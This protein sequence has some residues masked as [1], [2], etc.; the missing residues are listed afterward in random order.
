MNYRL[1]GL[2]YKVVF[3]PRSF[4]YHRL[5]GPRRMDALK[6]V[7]ILKNRMRFLAKH[8]PEKLPEHLFGF[9]EILL[10]PDRLFDEILDFVKRDLPKYF[11][12]KP[13]WTLQLTSG[14]EALRNFRARSFRTV[15]FVKMLSRIRGWGAGKFML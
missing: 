8:F 6:Q 12:N 5:R 7:I 4:V 2:G 15:P 13:E 9:G 3:A 10:L 14:A 11:E 1:R